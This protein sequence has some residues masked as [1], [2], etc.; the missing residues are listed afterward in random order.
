MSL[1]LETQ[2]QPIP[3]TPPAKADLGWLVKQL[4]AQRVQGPF[5][6]GPRQYYEIR[7]TWGDGKHT[8]FY[9]G[10]PEKVLAAARAAVEHGPN[11][12][13]RAAP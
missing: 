1:K 5:Q 11:P 8:W 6:I 13:R 9:D 2:E 3:L 10:T 12:N 4:S 7:I